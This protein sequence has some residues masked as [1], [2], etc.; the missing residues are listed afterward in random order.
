MRLILIGILLFA[1][2]S[3][4]QRISFLECRAGL[5]PYGNTVWNEQAHV[6]VSGAAE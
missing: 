3:A 6:C 1:L 2:A 4:L 5:N